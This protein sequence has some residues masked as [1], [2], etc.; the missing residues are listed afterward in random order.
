MT[1]PLYLAIDQ[2]GH[3]SRALIFDAGGKTIASAECAVTTY[4]PEAD[5]V[6][7]DSEEMIASIETAISEAVT[8]SGARQSQITAAGLA[9]QRSSI[10]CWDKSSGRALSPIISWQD[11]RNAQWLAQLSLDQQSLHNLTGLFASPHYGA[12]K[13][14]WCLDHLD[15]VHR[16]LTHQRLTIGPMAS[17]V[18]QR[19]TRRREPVTDPANG[20]RTLL[21]NLNSLDWE[22]KLLTQFGIPREILP[23]CVPSRFAFGDIEV[24]G[25]RIPL[26][27]VTGDQSA[28][29]FA[30]G[31]PRT[32]AAYTNLGTGAFIQRTLTQALHHPRLLSSIV[33]SD[34]AAIYALEGTV[35]GAG[36]ALQWFGQREQIPD[37]EAKLP[38]WLDQI[39]NPPLFINAVAGLAAPYWRPDLQSEF[40][41]D[42]DN[43]HK[44]VAVAESIIF[45]LQRNLEELETM[46]APVREIIA[47]GGLAQLDGLCQRL[48]DLSQKPLLRPQAHE[49]TAQGLAWLVAGLPAQW[50]SLSE[51]NRIE[52]RPDSALQQRYHNWRAALE[53]RIS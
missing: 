14:R 22:S 52:P 23:R 34:H 12:S 40:I 30:W 28:A 48:A 44:T 29:I 20:S 46:L 2:G 37:L 17:Y 47:S 38:L 1:T 45:L 42:A 18:V 32:D 15:E 27:V 21:M 13:M 19:L 39:D 7:H 53:D 11:R 26:T 25:L 31:K 3:A 16:A 51:A 35:N 43:A 33:Y 41:G 24:N 6:E 50:V 4:T 8:Q 5:W 9:T 49:A 36:R 10:V